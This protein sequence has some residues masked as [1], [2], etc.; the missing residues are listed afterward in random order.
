[1]TD[2]GEGGTT[3]VVE[4]S[5][6]PKSATDVEFEEREKAIAIAELEVSNLQQKIKE[7]EQAELTDTEG[8]G[9]DTDNYTTDTDTNDDKCSEAGT[10]SDIA[11]RYEALLEGLSWAEQLDLEEQLGDPSTLEARLPGRAIQLHEK[12]SSPA[13]KKE[14]HETFKHYQEKQDKA[15]LRRLRFTERKASKLTILNMKIGEVIEQRDKLVDERKGMIESKLKKAEEKRIQHIEGIRKKAHKEEEKL[16]EIA[17]INEL[18]AQN[19][20]MDM[21][22]QVE[23][24]D[25]NCEERL[26]EIAGERAK[27]AEQREEREA[28]AEER[29]RAMED[30]RQKQ[31]NAMMQRR[32]SREKRERPRQKKGDE[33][34]RMRDRSRKM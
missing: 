22:F 32:L 1:M 15:R 18:Q 34:W 26:A 3:I 29:R 25:E 28:K 14:P 10:I 17:F 5:V 2:S 11:S 19:T 31:K 7:T 33:Q 20:R 21:M 16:K 24:A 4:V 13:R 12:L 8:D 27:K 6:E 23:H 30:E 9:T